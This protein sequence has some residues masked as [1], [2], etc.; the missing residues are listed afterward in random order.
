MGLLDVLNSDEGR[1]GMGLLA[2]A[3]P[4]ADGAGFGQRLQEGMGSV[5]QW[6][7]QQAAQKMQE[8]QMQEMQSKLAQEKQ[9]RELAARF[10]GGQGLAPIQG[11]KLLPPQFQSG[12]L[13]SVGKPAGFDFEGYSNALAGIDPIKGLAMQQSLV[14]DNKPISVKAD[15]T[16]VD[17]RTFKP[18]FTA[19]K[20]L[21]KPAA[22][23]EYE[24]AV[25][26]GETKPFTQWVMDQKRAGATNVSTKIENKMGE[27]IAGQV[28]PM[29]KDTYTAANGA[30]QQ[31]DAANRII[32]AVD[33]GKIISGPLA[34]GRMKIAQICL[35]YTSPS[36][37]DLSTSRMPSS[38]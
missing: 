35:L 22:I 17:N 10:G 31:V 11:D 19:P 24:F 36:P 3:G 16:L 12:I 38:A 33:S 32:K 26:Q 13:P 5:D 1:L 25:S 6:K 30:V 27:S 8:M 37:R 14:K 21:T 23:Q 4:R 28:G 9:M 34:G 2:A 20:T 18:L 15:E 7:R 29:V